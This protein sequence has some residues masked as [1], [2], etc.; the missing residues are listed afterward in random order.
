M[1]N[2]AFILVVC[3]L[4]ASRLNAHTYKVIEYNK[5]TDKYQ[6]IS[7]SF[8]SNIYL[9]QSPDNKV[10]HKVYGPIKLDISKVRSYNNKIIV[11]TSTP[12]GKLIFIAI[13]CSKQM[14]NVT[15]LAMKWKGWESPFEDFEK[16]MMS[17]ICS[18]N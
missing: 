5:Y 11:P 14:I 17:Y 13:S 8:G 4:Q 15:D 9:S 1:K 18:M 2:I 16:R 3:L 10:K 12:N 7:N 6:T